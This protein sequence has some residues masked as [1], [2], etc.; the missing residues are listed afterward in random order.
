M[1]PATEHRHEITNLKRAPGEI[2]FEARIASET[3]R[4]WFRTETQ[5][6]PAAEVALAA[7]L[8]PAMRLGGTLRLEEPIS[9][10]VLRSV[11]EFQAIQRAWSTGWDFIDGPLHEIEVVALTRVVEPTPPKNRVAAFFDGGLDSWATVLSEPGVTDLIL[12]EGLD[13]VPTELVRDAASQLG[14][15][16]HVVRTNLRGLSDQ[17]I[18]WEA[19]RGC[20]AVAVAFLFE[21]LFDRILITGDADYELQER[22]GAGWMV[23]QLWS[24]EAL[25]IADAGGGLSRVARTRLVAEHHA[26]RRW[27]RVC[28]GNSGEAFDCGR[29]DDCLMT[30][31]TLE[32]FGLRDRVE[33]M[34]SEL[35][36][37]RVVDIEIPDPFQ[38]VLWEDVLDVA[39]AAERVD[40]ERA[41]EGPVQRAKRREGLSRGFRRRHG[42]GPAPSVRVAVIVPV[43]KQAH[44]MA[45]AVGSALAQ[46]A[47]FGVGVTIVDDGCPDPE[48]ARIGRALGDANPDRVDFLRQANAGVAAARN[49]GIR[50]AIRRWPDVEAFFFL[51]ADN[52]LSPR[53]I[54]ALWEPMEADS[55]LAWASPALEMF[56][57]STDGGWNVLG[58]HLPYRQL[59]TNQSDT[60]TLVRRTVFEAGIEFD[61]TM[62]KGFEDWEFFL[63]ASL[64]GFAGAGAGRCGFRYRR[65]PDSML[66]GA[67][68]REEQIKADIRQRHEDAYRAGSLCRREHAEAPRFALVR[69][70]RA[71]ALLM[72]AADLE[73]RRVPLAALCDEEQL[74][75]AFV[76]TTAT[77]VDLL[78]DRRLLAG[79][80]LRL[81]LELH[82]YGTVALDAG[83][84]RIAIA[85]K[86]AALASLRM[87]GGDVWIER[88]LELKGASVTAPL[89][90]IGRQEPLGEILDCLCA[91]PERTTHV[92]DS[93]KHWRFFQYR[94]L[95]QLDT[96]VPWAGA[97]GGRTL[98]ALS[99]TSA[100]A[101]WDA[102]VDRVAVARARE[103]DLAAHLVLTEVPLTAEQPV[104][105]FD[106]LT[107]LGGADRDSVTLLVERLRSG[108]DLIEDLTGGTH[109]AS[110]TERITA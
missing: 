32:A 16:L 47:T 59:F 78:R 52:L 108:A 11:R 50:Q 39:R 79:V 1:S 95:D 71:D 8:M 2:S 105:G 83:G 88:N 102:L 42:E 89:P 27:L 13:P 94:H 36:L 81:Q 65:V 58:P 63:R 64:A 96:T 80:L 97:D 109:P 74:A 72:A 51:D 9:P 103:P 100:G 84:E 43:W 66:V 28:A 86:P 55:K 17:L 104:G 7:C 106:T 76:L 62:R 15:A 61:E 54:A 60:G 19:Y 99:P 57:A 48:T 10:R 91:V 68:L 56:G 85:A 3:R 87:P 35:D 69:C 40:L 25:E 12:I 73:P 14:L 44:Y 82:S 29:C 22:S 92:C 75:D 67:Q 90:I 21:P 110:A 45:G 98:L 26:A 53:T 93:P 18:P 34:P 46:D 20:A 107:C 6:L 70:D 24:T 23:D 77:E 4:V 31:V 41:V 37:E 5:T 30:M 101:E 33:T 38:R 49:A